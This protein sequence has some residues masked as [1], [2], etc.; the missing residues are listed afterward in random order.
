[1]RQISEQL[2]SAFSSPCFDVQIVYNYGLGSI[3][4]E[5]PEKLR[6]VPLQKILT[7]ICHRLALH[8]VVQ[9]CTNWK[10]HKQK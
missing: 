2:L 9:L 4:K 10:L 3:K 6:K 5:Q 7:Q 8:C 1:M